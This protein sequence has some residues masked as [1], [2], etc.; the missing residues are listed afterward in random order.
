MTEGADALVVANGPM[1][2]KALRACEVL[3]EEGINIKVVNNPFLNTPDTKKIGEL[4]NSCS[5]RLVTVEDHQILGGAGSILS[6]Q[7]II[8]GYSFRAK[9]LGVTGGFGQSAY[10]ADQLYEKFNMDSSSIVA[11]IKELL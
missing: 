6:H 4:L 9:S 10:T 11:A 8:A 7:L 3:K 5:N 2:S 1:V